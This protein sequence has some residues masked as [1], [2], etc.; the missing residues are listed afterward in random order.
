MDYTQSRWSETS[1]WSRKAIFLANHDEKVLLYSKQKRTPSSHQDRASQMNRLKNLSLIPPTAAK[2]SKKSHEASSQWCWQRMRLIEI[3]YYLPCQQ[4]D[5]TSR[6]PSPMKVPPPVNLHS[7]LTR[8][9]QQIAFQKQHLLSS[10]ISQHAKTVRDDR[11]ILQ[12]HRTDSSFNTIN[13]HQ[14][15]T[16]TAVLVPS[17]LKLVRRNINSTN[18]EQCL[19]REAP[20]YCQFHETDAEFT[21]HDISHVHWCWDSFKNAWWP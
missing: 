11:T 15:K 16:S 1:R 5:E 2:L 3:G 12:C 13:N 10:S 18:V 8:K 14:S 7:P 19:A 6:K 21:T 4:N 20:H 17:E 9:C